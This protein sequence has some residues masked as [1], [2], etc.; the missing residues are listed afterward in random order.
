MIS[1]IFWLLITSVLLAPGQPPAAPP[2]KKDS[3]TSLDAKQRAELAEWR[4]WRTNNWD[5]KKEMTKKEAE[6]EAWSAANWNDERGMTNTE[7]EAVD[8]M[9][10]LNTQ[11][12]ELA[13]KYKSVTTK[14]VAELLDELGTL[15]TQ[16]RDL[17]TQVQKYK[18]VQ[19]H[20]YKIVQDNGGT[21][22][23][24]EITGDICLLLGTKSVLDKNENAACPTLEY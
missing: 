1:R 16:I 19:N 10:L 9:E 4:A 20:K 7:A 5:E 22:R 8:K 23:F 13:E 6:W 12:R 3:G 18:S 2:Q 17:K 14:S 15:Y 21:W 24:D 11:M